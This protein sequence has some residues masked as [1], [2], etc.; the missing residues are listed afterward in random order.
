MAIQENP[1]LPPTSR[2]EDTAVIAGDGY[3]DG[4]RPV[5]AGRGLDWIKAGWGTVK[6]QMGMWVL[7]ILVL[8]L[9]VLV[10]AVIP[11]IGSLALSLTMPAFVGGLMLACDRLER[12]EKIGVGDLFSGFQRSAGPLVLLGAIGLGL[13]IAAM[14]PATLL[15]FAI[16][17]AGGFSG[18]AFAP[19]LI[20]VMMAFLIPVYMALW[21]APAL[22]TLQNVPPG[23]AVAQSFRGCLRNIVP[24]LVYSLAIVPLAVIA[25]LPLGLGLLLLSPVLIAST[26]AAYR[27]IFFER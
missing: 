3:V 23:R 27:D 22:V 14:I 19:V 1:Y 8:G 25:T 2:V 6:R 4:G 26:Y 5:A 13:S 20:L 15:V 12:G 10:M 21:F 24:F 11:I 9:M 7:L 17:G 18:A 16:S